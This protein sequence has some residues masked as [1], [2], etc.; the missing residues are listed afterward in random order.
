MGMYDSFI[1]RTPMQCPVCCTGSYTEFQTKNLDCMLEY[2]H[3]GKPA[4]QYMWEEL[5]RQE[6]LNVVQMHNLL[7]G[8]RFL[9]FFHKY[10][11]TVARQL[12]DGEYP[13]YRYCRNC[14]EYFYIHA[15]VLD[16]V[17]IGIREKRGMEL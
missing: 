5:T 4:V 6:Y 8:D 3:E 14:N 7:Y 16:G 1:L 9:P 13:A 12:E 15:I 10:S 17:F 2:Y 11:D